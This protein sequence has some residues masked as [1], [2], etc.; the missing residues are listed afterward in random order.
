MSDKFDRLCA[1]VKRADELRRR[2]SEGAYKT[3]ISMNG[4]P[5]RCASLPA[6]TIGK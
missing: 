2:V 1:L 4:Q 3:A 5:D 6:I